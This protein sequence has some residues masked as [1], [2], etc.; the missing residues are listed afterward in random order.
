MQDVR[1]NA[2]LRAQHLRGHQQYDR[3][4]QADP[5]ARQNAG[6]CAWQ[7]DFPNDRQPR[8]PEALAHAD[9]GP[10]NV[11]DGAIGGHHGGRERAKGDERVLRSLADAEPDHEERQKRNFRDRED[12]RHDG[13]H[14]RAHIGKQAD[15]DTQGD[16]KADPDE[17]PHEQAAQ[18][19][20]KVL[21]QQSGRVEILECHEN[22]GRSRQRQRGNP[23]GA[24][25]PLGQ[26]GDRCEHHERDPAA[27]A[28]GEAAPAIFDG[29]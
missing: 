26:N 9:Q 7:N 25:S 21:E 3:D 24:G 2:V 23:A 17:R 22:V 8:Q 4:H 1:A 20:A 29:T 15:K 14:S 10:I 18:G 5:E 19:R 16:A 12:C 13:H 11:V 28:G 6:H 27:R